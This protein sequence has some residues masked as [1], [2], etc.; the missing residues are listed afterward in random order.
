[1]IFK[2]RLFFIFF[3][4]CL[5]SAYYSQ[6]AAGAAPDQTV[7]SSAERSPEVPVNGIDE[8]QDESQIVY[9]IRTV[10]FDTQGRTKVSALMEK[11]EFILGENI[12]GKN[13]LENYINRKTQ[14]LLNERVLENVL[15]EYTLA[16]DDENGLIPV[17]LLINTTDTL[18][19]IILPEP[20]YD[21]NSG[22]E[23]T[24]KARDYNFLGSMTPLRIDLGYSYDEEGKHSVL[25]GIDSDIP[26]R[27]FGYNWNLNFDHEFDN[28]QGKPL[29]YKNTTGLS[30]VLPFKT[31]TFTFGFN[32][33]IL[34][35]EE[36]D[37]SDAIDDGPYFQDRWYMSSEFY[38]QWKI[39]LGITVGRFGPL[40]YTPK[41]TGTINYRPNGELG[42]YREGPSIIPGQS[43]GFGEI[44]WI[45]NYRK[46]LEVSLQN[47][48]TYNI[49]R[50]SWA[51]NISISAIGHLPLAEDIGISG[52]FMYR[53]WFF[54]PKAIPTVFG[55]GYFHVY[56]DGGDAL[57][58]IKNNQLPVNYMLSLNLDFPVRLFRFVPSEWYNNPKLHFF[59]F[60]LHGSPFIDIALAEDP[61]HKR[62]FSFKD[63][64]VAGGVEVI[65]FPLA[66]RSFYLR[67]SLGMDLREFLRTG[68]FFPSGGRELFIGVGHYY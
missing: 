64:L 58:G 4:C 23:I 11:G 18:N 44:N 45:G 9:Y 16:A 30:M 51:N 17:D 46:G 6:E 47:S 42:E 48:N 26:F 32:Q 13:N 14:L 54:D 53:H 12:K 63:T 68:R 55:N 22:F 8:F 35:N 20:K 52:R 2:K 21:S 34:V 5:F 29:Y 15:I 41:L 28:T 40:T 27:A 59:D 56:S 65:V 43:I 10:S 25:L 49:Y 1:M 31:T 3:V 19:I 33:S 24:L 36:N 57:R 66:M 37:T 7:E 61:V 50:T 39:P 67:M 60:E 38:G 62:S